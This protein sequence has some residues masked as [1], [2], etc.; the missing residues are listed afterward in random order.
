MNNRIKAVLF[1]FDGV[2]MDTESLYTEFWN[3]MGRRY[4]HEEAFGPK[5]KGQSLVRIFDEHFAGRKADQ[6]S[7]EEQLDR[8]ER[9]MPY[10]YVPGAQAFLEHLRERQ[11]P[12]VVVTSSNGKKMDNV[13]RVHPE[14]RSY[15][16]H[17][18]TS[19]QFTLS[20]PDPECFLLGMR[21]L[22]AQPCDTVIFEDSFHGLQAARAA[23]TFVVGV[24]TTNPRE[25]IIPKADL[26]VDDLTGL[27]LEDLSAR[28]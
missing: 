21:L 12:A 10:D 17:I 27:T 16:H 19:E 7:V 6:V 9:E 8:F 22:D 25:A 3:E 13:Y 1:D 23:G 24:A 5:I 18:V 26:V 4:L 28:L 15:F 14:F 20:K 2:L 11:V